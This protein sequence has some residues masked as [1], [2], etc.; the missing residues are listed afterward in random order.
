MGTNAL[1]HYEPN[2]RRLEGM[3]RRNLR[4]SE[5]R[6]NG[7]VAIAVSNLILAEVLMNAEQGLGARGGILPFPSMQ[8]SKLAE[9]DSPRGLLLNV[10][11]CM[12]SMR[13]GNREAETIAVGAGVM[14][15]LIAQLE[16]VDRLYCEIF[17][18]TPV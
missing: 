18:C 5:G 1:R 17:G 7:E 8:D 12:K 9:P 3:I 16:K 11:H 10:I 13:E 6:S 2:W 14:E 15:S 4:I